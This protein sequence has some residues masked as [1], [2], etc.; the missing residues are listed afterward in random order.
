MTIKTGSTKKT[1]TIVN[2]ILD[3]SGSMQTC[4]EAAISGF[5][6]Y[7]ANL[8]Q[9]DGDILLSLTKF[10]TVTE[11]VHVAK[12]LSDIPDLTTE[13]YVPGGMT[14]LYDAIASTVKAVEKEASTDD[15]VLCVIM[16][17]G[18][19]NWSRETTQAQV[20]E[21][22]Q[23][24]EKLGNWTF[25]YLG[26]N[27]DAFVAGGGI[28]IQVGNT[29]NYTSDNHGHRRA[30]RSVADAT[31]SYSAQASMSTKDFFVD[32]VKPDIKNVIKTP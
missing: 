3:E 15:R 8:K 20:K 13:T 19:E 7:V 23:T 5:N 11:V 32:E 24:K 6:E 22:I 31:A 10:N 4:R 2:Y 18:H 17:D 25:V 21:L 27:Q 29:L 9:D 30:M 16:T 12:R 28:G 14:A 26:A 1:R